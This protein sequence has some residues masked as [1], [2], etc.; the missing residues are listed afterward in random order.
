MEKEIDSDQKDAQVVVVNQITE[1]EKINV[2]YVDIYDDD[3]TSTDESEFDWS[4]L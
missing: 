3:Y 2:N 4:S 1:Q